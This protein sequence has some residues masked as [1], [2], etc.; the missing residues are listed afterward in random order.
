MPESS[1]SQL[2]NLS[3]H[4]FLVIERSQ[5]GQQLS[6]QLWSQPDSLSG[7][8]DLLLSTQM[9][10]LPGSPEW[11][12]DLSTLDLMQLN[13]WQTGSSPSSPSLL[14][15]SVSGFPEYL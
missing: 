9:R 11:L 2:V 13:E 6:I 5:N 12:L 7:K 1:N 3:L 10:K 4:R 14:R 15:L 8:A